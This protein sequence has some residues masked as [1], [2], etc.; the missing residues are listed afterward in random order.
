MHFVK[1]DLHIMKDDQENWWA[2]LSPED[3]AFIKRFLLASG[4]LKQL[5]TDYGVSYPTVRLRLNRLIEKVNVLE[6]TETTSELER[7]ARLLFADHKIDASTLK[8]LLKAHN[9]DR[10]QQPPASS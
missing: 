4:S 10:E 3:H 6:L 2:E 5:A 9:R 1:V 8:A 7:T